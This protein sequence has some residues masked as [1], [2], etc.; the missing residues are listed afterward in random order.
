[1]KFI[2]QGLQFLW[3]FEYKI[4][5]NKISSGTKLKLRSNFANTMPSCDLLLIYVMSLN[6]VNISFF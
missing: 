2:R 3:F 4:K 1:M 6:N 5:S